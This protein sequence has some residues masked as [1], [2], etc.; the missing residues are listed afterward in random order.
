MR[1]LEEAL[2]PAVHF[3]MSK[4]VFAPAGGLNLLISVISKNKNG[5]LNTC[6]Y[7]PPDPKARSCCNYR[8]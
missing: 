1:Q 2:S 7:A 6:L 5:S 4:N 3:F 8:L